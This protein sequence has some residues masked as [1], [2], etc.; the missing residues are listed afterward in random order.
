MLLKKIYLSWRPGKE[1]GRYLVDVFSRENSSGDDIVLNTKKMK[2]QK[3]E[4]KAL[5]L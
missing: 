5:A 3:L 2:L 1:D 4:K